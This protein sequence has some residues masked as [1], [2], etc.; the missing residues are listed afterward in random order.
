MIKGPGD[1]TDRAG[2]DVGKKRVYLIFEGFL[3]PEEA[4]SL[5]ET[6]RKAIAEVGAGYTVLSYFKD[7]TPGTQEVADVFSEMVTMASRAGCRKAARVSSGS[8]LGPLQMGRVAK[9][10]S[11]YPSRHF[12]TWEE[13]EA[14]L[15]RDES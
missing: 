8:L 15:D 5:K 10:T 6:Y 11:S 7:F 3:S 1:V 9:G 12:E 14:Y 13:A 4:R 2:V